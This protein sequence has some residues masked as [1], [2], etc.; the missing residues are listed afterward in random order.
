MKI[1]L[2]GLRDGSHKREWSGPVSGV[3]LLNPD[4]AAEVDVQAIIH[5]LGDLIT[6]RG[7]LTGHYD[8]KCDRCL[9]PA[10]VA[11]TAPLEV[12]IR[13]RAVAVDPDEGDEGEYIV[14]ASDDQVEVDLMDQIRDRIVVEMPM[15]AQCRD[16][17]KGLCPHCGADLNQGPCECSP[18]TDDR[19]AGLK[20]IKLKE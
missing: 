5:R 6:V 18:E 8:R 17:C 15:S 14:S 20:S 2:D 9:R 7:E 16:D 3:D 10:S 4:A 1:N 12:V 19:W 11:M 13:Q